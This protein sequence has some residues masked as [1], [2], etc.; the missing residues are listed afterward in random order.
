MDRCTQHDPVDRRTTHATV[1]RPVIV[2]TVTNCGWEHH[3]GY[4]TP[5][6]R[7]VS[8]QLSHY[9][10]VV[11][12]IREPRDALFQRL[13]VM[14]RC[15]LGTFISSQRRFALDS[16]YGFRTY[17]FCTIA[18]RKKRPLRIQACSNTQPVVLLRD[19]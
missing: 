19:C 5:D 17:G 9:S 11:G 1:Q 8:Q 3:W 14:N 15:C 12:W 13:F 4:T 18:L 7:V 16:T 10:N 6:T 2:S